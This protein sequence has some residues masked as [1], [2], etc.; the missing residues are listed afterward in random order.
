MSTKL[1]IRV[2]STTFGGFETADAVFSTHIAADLADGLL[3]DWAPSEELFTFK[4]RKAW[5]NCEPEANFSRL[6]CGLWV[7]VRSRLAPHEFLHHRHPD[8]RLR[9][10]HITHFGKIEVNR[11]SDRLQRAVAIVSNSGGPPWRRHRDNAY[12]N[13][14]VTC[15]D[16]DL[17]GR[18]HWKRYRARWFSMPRPP[19]NYKGC[20]PGDWPDETKR[21]LMARYIVAVCLENFSE[22]LYFSEKFVEAVCAGCIPVYRAHPSIA[23]TVLNGARWVD[24]QNYGN[25]PHHTIRAALALDREDVCRQNTLWLATSEGLHASSLEE[26]FRRIAGILSTS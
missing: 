19:R 26:V 9:V 1:Q 13:K 24:P 18:M 25:D 4:R 10:P 2:I 15:P 11:A 3:C 20:L 22:P 21:K 8:L 6:D 16:V 14:F 17:F 5:Y 12:R 23:Q 7:G